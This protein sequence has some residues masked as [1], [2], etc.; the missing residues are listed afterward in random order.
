MR[1]QSCWDYG[2]PGSKLRSRLSMTSWI[3]LSCLYLFVARMLKSWRDSLPLAVIFMS[4]LAVSQMS[5]DVWVGPGESWIHWI[6]GCG[7]VGTCA[8]GQNSESSGPWCFQSCSMDVRWTLTRDLRWRLNFFGTRS[9]WRI[10]LENW[11]SDFV[12]NERLLRETQMRFVA[13]IVHAHQLR[14]YG[15]VAH[16][17]DADPA[18]QILSAREPRELGRPLGRPR[19]SW[20]QQVD[21]HLKEMGM[22][23]LPGG[24]PDR[25]P[26]TS[27]GK[28][29]QQR[30]APAHAPKPDLT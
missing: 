20:L 3:L 13:C 19:A 14:L 23:H 1:N 26:R 4:L 18:H 24:W 21:L 15:H 8:G 16:F 29:T 22:G 10:P 12:S 2:F 11:R 5:T 17:P 7:A 25:G 6:T 30:A 28:L 9:L 27:G